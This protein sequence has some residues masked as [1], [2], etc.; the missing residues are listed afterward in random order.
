MGR[1]MGVGVSKE[2][3]QYEL[4]D[5][6]D[7]VTGK[8]EESIIVMDEN[9]GRA[10]RWY[11]KMW[12]YLI[13]ERTVFIFIILSLV[14]AL[15]ALTAFFI[16]FT[17]SELYNVIESTLI[18][19]GPMIVN[20]ISYIIYSMIFCL[21]S[22][23]VVIIVS[24]YSTG[25]GIPEMKCILSG[26]HIPH[27]LSISTLVAKVLGLVCAF[28]GGLSI[29]KEGP[30]VHISSILANQVL[31]FPLWKKISS[32]ESLRFQILSA[33]CAV[34]VSSSFGSPVGGV[35]FSVEVTSTYYMVENLW[36]G[37]WCSMCG[38]LVIR[39]LAEFGFQVGLISLFR[40]NNSAFDTVT[41]SYDW[42]ELGVFALVGITGGILGALFV[43]ITQRLIHYS[44][45]VNIFQGVRGTL[46]RAILIGFIVAL[47]SYPFPLVRN[48]QQGMDYLFSSSAN[49][50]NEI[51]FLCGLVIV[52]FI[53]TS[54]S[55][56]AGLPCGVYTPLFVLGAA[57]G[58]LVGELIAMIWS[59]EIA[60]ISYAVVGAASLC[61]SSTHT[62]S[63]AVI[64]VELTGQ[65]RL[66]LPILLSVLL[67]DGIGKLL[68]KSIYDE[69]LL[70]KG[71][72]YMRSF[73]VGS[74]SKNLTAQD[75]MQPEDMMCYLTLTSTYRD[76]KILFEDFQHLSYSFPL[77]ES[78]ETM[79]LLGTIKRHELVKL[80]RDMKKQAKEIKKQEQR[81]KEYKK[82]LPITLEDS[83]IHIGDGVDPP[84]E[85]EQLIQNSSAPVFDDSDSE[86][87]SETGRVS[88]DV[89]WSQPIPYVFTTS[90]NQSE[91]RDTVSVDPTPFQISEQVSISKI[92]FI[93]TMLGLR[94]AYV[95]TRGR[96][97]GIITK[98]ILLEHLD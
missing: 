94:E 73:E 14:G 34:G 13:T 33:A 32:N 75:I 45:K 22:A 78:E 68:S 66:L 29:G 35:L 77:V 62:I 1:D 56:L 11:K 40:L 80:F 16:D 81:W 19:F 26:V 53:T 47:L 10:T 83:T 36:K 3:V 65:F 76:A 15:S 50:L 43:Q 6:L 59:V 85:R 57:Y 87:S 4:V 92:H 5:V 55:Q 96:L 84:Q 69:L 95:T 74:S 24:T 67:A 51:P 86:T 31:K 90:S 61:A 70:Q 48:D 72:P 18:G 28:S 42:K 88:L 98:K 97:Q 8:D 91:F 38:A 63:T 71:L 7:S 12:S 60:P 44:K 54:L 27:Y 49:L 64:V 82:Q 89:V 17:I 23:L 58:R 9:T 21:L 30:Y 25:S 20:Y 93:F 39:L 37:F 41:E 52:K 79:V 46:I 2:R